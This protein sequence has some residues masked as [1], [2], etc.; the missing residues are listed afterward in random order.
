MEVAISP[1]SRTMVFVAALLT[2]VS[3]HSRSVPLPHRDRIMGRS[4]LPTLS[5]V[6]R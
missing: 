2:A 1:E 3:G 4:G 6:F 5:H